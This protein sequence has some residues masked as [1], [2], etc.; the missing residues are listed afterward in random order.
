MRLKRS[1]SLRKSWYGGFYVFQIWVIVRLSVICNSVSWDSF[2]WLPFLGDF[3]S[4]LKFGIYREGT[5]IM[6][7]VLCSTLVWYIYFPLNPH[8]FANLVMG[9]VSGDA[10]RFTSLGGTNTH[11]APGANTL[12]F[13]HMDAPVLQQLGGRTMLAIS[14][15]PFDVLLACENWSL[16]VD[17]MFRP[18][19]MILQFKGRTWL[20]FC[21]LESGVC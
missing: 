19:V 17:D 7:S 10:P 15:S 4:K 21:M 5:L 13:W 6:N 12:G 18:I 1:I 16:V 14:A 9:G 3:R 2:C 11:L 8:L 20:Y